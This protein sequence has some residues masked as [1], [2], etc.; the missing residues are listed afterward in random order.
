[1]TPVWIR[2]WFHALQVAKQQTH[3]NTVSEVYTAL[4][5]CAY[6]RRIFYGELT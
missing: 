2:V 6:E 3:N 5:R 1:M 4:D